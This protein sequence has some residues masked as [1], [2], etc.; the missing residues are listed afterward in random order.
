MGLTRPSFAWV[1]TDGARS[2]NFATGVQNVILAML[3]AAVLALANAYRMAT[4]KRGSE[5]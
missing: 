3:A 1:P 4:E 5:R 2:P